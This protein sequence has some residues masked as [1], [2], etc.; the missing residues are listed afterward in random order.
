[1]GQLQTLN[2]PDCRRF[3][4]QISNHNKVNL[5][6]SIW[7]LLIKMIEPL[8]SEKPRWGSKES[9][10]DAF[11]QCTY[12]RFYNKRLREFFDARF[13]LQLKETEWLPDEQGNLHQPSELFAP[14]DD[15]RKVLGNSV[16][17]LDSNF[18]ISQENETSRWLAEKL[19]I[20]LNAN[21]ESVLNYLETLSG[22]ETSVE[23]VEPLYRF[24]ARQDARPR[25]EF[26]Q[27][28]LIFTTNPEPRWWKADEVFWKDESPVFGNH[29]GYLERNYAAYEGTLK[30]FFTAS[31]VSESAAPSDYARV[32][33]EV[34]SSEKAGNTEV[35]NRVET[36]Y[37]RIMPYLR[38]EGNSLENEVWQ[39]EW[40]RTREGRC[41]LG[42]KGNEWGF[43]FL[44]E[45]V[46][47]DDDYRYQLFKDKIPFWAF[48]NDLLE[49]AKN[50]EVKGC[51]ETSDVEFDY[52]GDQGGYQNWSE[53]VRNLRPYIH[54]FLNSPRLC[55]KH[56]DH[57]SLEV[58]DRLSARRAQG[59]KVMYRLNGVPVTDPDPRQS[60]LDTTKSD[61]SGMLWLG[62]E[63][64][65]GAYPD[66][67]GDALQDHFGINQLREFVKDL[68]LI[69]DL[70]KTTLFWEKRGFVSNLCK[71]PPDIDS[72]E[73]GD[74]TAPK[75]VDEKLPNEASVE[76]DS[77]INNSE[78]ETPTVHEEPET[79]N[80]NNNSTENQ[81]ETSTYQSSPSKSR[82]R[83]RS[84]TDSTPDGNRR[85]G[86]SPGGG[87]EG[88]AHRTLKEHL[89]ANPSLFGEGLKL[90]DTEYR[91]RS[92]DEADVLFED[93]SGNPVTV[94]VK[95]LILSGSDQEAW[96]AVKYKHL[97]AVEY[98]LPCEQVRSILAAPKIP[99]D[100][101]AKCK[102]LGIEPIEVS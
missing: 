78:I 75:L 24:L 20:H 96:Q 37:R 92:G 77:E 17:Y 52:S 54:D 13:Y 76:D 51:F 89:A 15:N 56:E 85:P 65:E 32:I 28:P 29:R 63:E 34:T 48:S 99:D 49:L 10:R 100:V 98:G 14:T 84:G 80:G 72:K 69:T 41:W 25:E 79:E 74:K 86:Y 19:G 43:F 38:E 33:R 53:K 23:K 61:Q 11:F 18:N 101:R 3:F 81:P 64:D 67:V 40:K 95:P 30:P 35:R 66:L 73:D 93:S 26:E 39:R 44:H 1:M 94:E 83:P 22:T 102:E 45:L 2:L 90:V 6:I 55:E 59:L 42:K 21:T 5:S 4:A 87:G 60:F 47:K 82:K 12:Q 97:A 57:K 27:K 88:E 46:W 9:T 16:A 36:L 62:I 31:G 50:L 8:S 58:L 7:S 68:L 70:H 91:F 71:L